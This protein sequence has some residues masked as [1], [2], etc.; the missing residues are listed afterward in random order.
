MNDAERSKVRNTVQAWNRIIYDAT[1]S[2]L[3]AQ[4]FW[5]KYQIKS[6]PLFANHSEFNI[7][8]TWAHPV[9]LLIQDLKALNVEFGQIKEKY[10]TLRVY[11]KPHSEEAER[12]IERTREQ[13]R[14]LGV[15]PPENFLD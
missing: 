13:L 14:V 5:D 6:S 15:H 12:I 8:S 10:C 9:D 11:Y 3:G 4:Y 7:P 1:P 2:D